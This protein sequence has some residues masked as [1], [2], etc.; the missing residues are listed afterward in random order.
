MLLLVCLLSACT[1]SQSIIESPSEDR[2]Q[3]YLTVRPFVTNQ[4]TKTGSVLSGFSF[5]EGDE[6]GIV[7]Y[8]L[9]GS[10]TEHT[11]QMPLRMTG[12][13]EGDYAEFTSNIGWTLMTNGQYKY[14]AY[15]PYTS[16]YTS[17]GIP[18]DFTTQLQTANNSSAHTA[19]YDVLYS[20]PVL[21]VSSSSPRFEM[22]HL[23]ALAK[24]V[25]TVPA[26][27]GATEFKRMS[28]QSNN[29]IFV[30]SG[31]CELGATVS[32]GS[33]SFTP[34]EHSKQLGMS[35]N[36]LSPTENKL[37]V[38]MMMYPAE[39]EG[40]TLTLHLW[41]AHI[42][43]SLSG[44]VVCNEDQENGYMYTYN[45]TVDASDVPTFLPDRPAEGEQLNILLVGHSFGVD[46][47]EYLPALMVESG[48]DNVN[49]GRFFYPNCDL[50]R[51]YEYYVNETP[52]TYYYSPAGSTKYIPFY[53]ESN[54]TLKEVINDTAWDLIVFQQSISI[55]GAGDYSTYQP[56]L[57]DL[58]DA[59]TSVRRKYL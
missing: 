34:S 38:Y 48:I 16:D 47:T 52:Y 57:N 13:T 58:L 39:L 6:I 59:I 33:P 54:K 37:T 46:A 40:K 51:H 56:Y 29:N 1:R 14:I 36:N 17:S 27:Y 2:I 41:A 8:N 18:I 3:A 5:S 10:G 15:Y 35:L 24:F 7:P 20:D 23:C 43:R 9:D 31:S 25:I 32:S 4:D 12:E 11:S 50:A 22:N 44:T 53:G 49:I 28:I 21:P 45:V 19:A 42:S 55:E 30:R 26:E